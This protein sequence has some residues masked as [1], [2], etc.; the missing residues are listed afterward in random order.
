MLV[1]KLFFRYTQFELTQFPLL[2]VELSVQLRVLPLGPLVLVVAGVR[3]GRRRRMG[4]V[5][6][7]RVQPVVAARTAAH[8]RP[9]RTDQLGRV[10]LGGTGPGSRLVAG[11]NRVEERRRCTINL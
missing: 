6:L 1:T 7:R 10:H 4:H 9:V 2:L 8:V 5:A 3:V 11:G